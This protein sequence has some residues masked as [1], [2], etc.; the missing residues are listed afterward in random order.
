MQF[1]RL[2]N[3]FTKIRSFA[4]DCN[5]FPIRYLAI[6]YLYA[7]VLLAAL[8]LS[9]GAPNTLILPTMLSSRTAAHHSDKS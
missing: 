2:L 5:I 6:R 1:C 9:G 3:R 4:Y 8:S 7:S